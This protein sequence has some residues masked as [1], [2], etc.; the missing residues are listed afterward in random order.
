LVSTGSITANNI[1]ANNITTSGSNA[2]RLPNL[3]AVEIA[4]LSPLNGDL[5]YNTTTGYAQVYQ[6]GIWVEI[7]IARYS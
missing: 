5:V 6:Q 4:A 3:T 2:F 1:I 7:T